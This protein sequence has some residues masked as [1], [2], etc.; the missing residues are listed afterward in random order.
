[1]LIV[2]KKVNH[3]FTKPEK[4]TNIKSN[5]SDWAQCFTAFAL[6][7]KKNRASCLRAWV[8][9]ISLSCFTESVSLDPPLYLFVHRTRWRPLCRK[10]LKPLNPVSDNTNEISCKM[11]LNVGECYLQEIR[12]KCTQLFFELLLLSVTVFT[13]SQ[14]HV[15]AAVLRRQSLHEMKKCDS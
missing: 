13:L 14:C 8:K 11:C 5:M 15:C 2:K 1:M 4:E 6:N 10:R 7:V 9:M 3:N 12:A